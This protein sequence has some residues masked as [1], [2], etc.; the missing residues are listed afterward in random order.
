MKISFL[1]RLEILATL[2]RM[3]PILY[4]IV[5]IF[6]AMMIPGFNSFYIIII[7]LL[8]NILNFFLKYAVM[9]PIYKLAGTNN[10]FLL[11]MGSRPMGASS[12]GL[13]I[14]GK[15]ATTFGMPS[16]HS[17]IAFTIGTYL[18]CRLI[19]RFIDNVNQNNNSNA[20]ELIL[21]DIWIFISICLI[22]FIMI[23]ICYS[24][25]YIEKCHTIQQV[26]I[27]G[28]FGFIFGFLAF[29]FE[30]NIRIAILGS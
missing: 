21:D 20:V 19:N 22:L 30:K 18:I 3:S 1:K 10:L 17:Q 15:K 9:K 5:M 24:R 28:I 4:L 23:Y 25:V 14:D 29:Y 26:S 16:G 12:C 13:V 11:G 8:S 2:A 27:G 7:I 6:Y